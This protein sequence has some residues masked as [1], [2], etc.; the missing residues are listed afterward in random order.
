MDENRSLHS[1]GVAKKM[2]EILEA[3]PHS[4][5]NYVFPRLSA[6]GFHDGGI[7]GYPSRTSG[8]KTSAACRG[9]ALGKRGLSPACQ[10][11]GA[12]TS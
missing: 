3:P 5:G 6:G 8:K 10:G 12:L 1:L 4:T 7:A 9:T 2:V 11:C